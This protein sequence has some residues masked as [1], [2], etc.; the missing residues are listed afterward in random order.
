MKRILYLLTFTFLPCFL[1]AQQP[2]KAPDT[3]TRVNKLNQI[4]VIS[5]RRLKLKMIRFPML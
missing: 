1:Q 2:K 4:N 5:R 3:T